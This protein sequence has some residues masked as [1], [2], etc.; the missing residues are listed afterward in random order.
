V[1]VQKGIFVIGFI[2]STLFFLHPSSLFVQ[3]DIFKVRIAFFMDGIISVK[4]GFEF[5]W[6]RKMKIKIENFAERCV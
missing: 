5:S 1:F 4:V 2:I 3:K 6:L